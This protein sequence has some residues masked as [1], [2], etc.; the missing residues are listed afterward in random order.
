ME[1]L[2]YSTKKLSSDKG[3]ML[4]LLSQIGGNS[5]SGT[6]GVMSD[7]FSPVWSIHIRLHTGEKILGIGP[8]IPR[9]NRPQFPSCQYIPS[10]QY[11]RRKKTEKGTSVKDS[12]HKSKCV[13][14]FV[15]TC[16]TRKR[17][18]DLC[19]DDDDWPLT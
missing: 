17:C 6:A 19:V 13:F 18:M 16:A 12:R 5:F 8:A 7:F 11:E 4:F 10:V 14:S 2:N 9:T 15:A 3:D 1:I